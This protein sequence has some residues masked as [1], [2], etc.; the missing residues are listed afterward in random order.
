L[1]RE[2]ESARIDCHAL[3][4]GESRVIK[5]VSTTKAAD[6][7]REMPTRPIKTLDL[8]DVVAGGDGFSGKRNRGIDPRTGKAVDTEVLDNPTFG[9]GKYHCVVGH[10]YIDGVFIPGGNAPTQLDSG[11]HTYPWFPK[12]DNKTC[13]SFWTGGLGNDSAMLENTD[14]AS[15]NHGVLLVNANKGITFNLE[16]IWKANPGYKPLRFR[17]VAGNAERAS[18]KGEPVYADVWVFVDGQVSW[19][20]RQI[21]RYNGAMPIMIPLTANDRFLTL[22]ATD[23]G[24]GYQQDHIIFGDPRLELAPAKAATGTTTTREAA[25][26]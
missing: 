5:V 18:E 13:E 14:Y 26:H 21:N 10:P 6:F 12:T 4:E 1:L 25:K 23:G 20:R 22:V 2:N 8:V 16:A 9:D 11:G 3:R 15:A 19:R 24:N 7:I 17:A